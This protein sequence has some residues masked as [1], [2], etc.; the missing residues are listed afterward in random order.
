VPS[1]NGKKGKKGY[2][3][4]KGRATNVKA[5]ARRG[6]RFSPTMSWVL[7]VGG[8]VLVVGVVVFIS[9]RETLDPGGTGVTDEQAWDLP[10]LDESTDPGGDGR[11]TLAEFAGTPTVVNFFASW[12]VACDR[13]LPVFRDFVEVYE[14]EV[15][16]VFVNSN[17]TGNWRPMAEDNEIIGLQLAK[18]I[19][20]TRRNGLYRN[21][22]GTGGMPITA[23][24]D[25]EGTL[26]DT[27]FGEMNS[28]SLAQALA[29]L[30]VSG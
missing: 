7:V 24:Y 25:A 9:V 11:V 6:P 18:D 8:I 23:F 17:E 15:D 27:S 22:G 3:A 4:P 16:F 21:L 13:E 10:A 1:K 14:G 30:G 20:G 12:C 5:G 28:N 2:T 19:A 26:V 29:G